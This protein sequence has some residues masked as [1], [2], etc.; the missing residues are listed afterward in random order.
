MINR[1]RSA[2]LSGLIAGLLLAACSTTPSTVP[3]ATIG[4]GSSVGPSATPTTT[5]SSAASESAAP[6]A[7]LTSTEAGFACATVR[8]GPTT[9]RAQL[10]DIRLGTH[11]GFDRVTF[12]FDAGLPRY[13]VETATPP[14]TRDASGMPIDINGSAFLRV[15]LEGGTKVLPNGG[16][17]Y[18]GATE[19]KPGYPKI[20]HV[21]EAGDFEAVSTWYVGLSSDGCFRVTALSSPARLAIDV[22]Q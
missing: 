6:T 20:V 11:A 2:P 8:G 7:V 12:Q 22:E 3:S 5:A 18:V 17:S 16:V 15:T 10:S 9:E 19:F 13:T 21:V 4:A 1:H 14:F